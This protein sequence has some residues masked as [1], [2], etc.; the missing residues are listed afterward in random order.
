MFGRLAIPP[1]GFGIVLF[2]P[3][4]VL[5]HESERELRIR[6]ALLRRVA[7]P[8]HGLDLSVKS[9]GKPFEAGFE[10]DK[11]SQPLVKKS[12]DGVR[13]FVSRD[14][15][16]LKQY[17]MRQGTM[18]GYSLQA[19]SASQKL[20][21][22]EPDRAPELPF[23]TEQQALM[24]KLVAEKEEELRKLA[25]LEEQRRQEEAAARAKREEEQKRAQEEQARRQ[26]EEA[27][28]RAEAARKAEE[29]RQAMISERK[30]LIATGN[31]QDIVKSFKSVYD[32]FSRSWSVGGGFT[33]RSLRTM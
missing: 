33:S 8:L 15:K 31:Q 3:L 12:I 2:D 24:A 30:R 1:H 17:D 23:T 13:I 18:N 14:G 5:I 22:I 6:I 11:A 10:S 28:R 19:V 25:E 9:D 29:A 32:S 27:M 20:V 7:I 26:Q 16:S 21:L 4:A